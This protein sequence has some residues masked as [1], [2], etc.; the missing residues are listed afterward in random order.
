MWPAVV[1]KQHSV[2]TLSSQ[3]WWAA[4]DRTFKI[5]QSVPL[6]P[7]FKKQNANQLSGKSASL[8]FTG[9]IEKAET[10]HQ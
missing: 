1:T 2:T 10:Q 7:V 4:V 3:P 6:G 9:V 8:S 5:D